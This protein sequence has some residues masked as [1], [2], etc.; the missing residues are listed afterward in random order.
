MTRFEFEQ[1]QSNYNEQAGS[2]S[3]ET[4]NS[5]KANGQSIQLP[6]SKAG[7][8]VIAQI[9]YDE[10]ALKSLIRRM[11]L[12]VTPQRLVILRHL[13]DGPRHTTVQELYDKVVV[14]HP[15]VG[16]ATVYRLLKSM[17][18]SRLVTETRIG[19]LPARYELTPHGHHDHLTCSTC[20]QI[21]EFENR[22]IE[23]LQEKI[24]KEFGFKL[25]HHVLELYGVCASCQNRLAKGD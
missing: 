8:L 7:D 17:T 11:H 25:T 24:A 5:G 1:T 16:F 12:K 2:I 20:G 10:A 13:V 14:Q 15:D 18:E 3:F 9:E 4:R 21:Y 19:G 23:D 6:T 22:S